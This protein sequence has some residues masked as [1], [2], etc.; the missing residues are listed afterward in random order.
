L[1]LLPTAFAPFATPCPASFAA[2]AVEEPAADISD[3]DCD[4]LLLA[5]FFALCFFAFVVEVVFVL[6]CVVVDDDGVVDV[7][8]CANANPVAN[9]TAKINVRIRFI[10]ILLGK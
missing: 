5:A 10:A 1:V 6:S 7:L 2:S 3:C 8:A 9:V 4:A